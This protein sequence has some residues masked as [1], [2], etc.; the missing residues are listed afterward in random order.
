MRL[1]YMCL[2]TQVMWSQII[3]RRDKTCVECFQ[4]ILGKEISSMFQKASR[5]RNLRGY[6]LY[7][8]LP[9]EIAI[10]IDT[11]IACIHNSIKLRAFNFDTRIISL[12][13]QGLVLLL[14]GN[15]HWTSFKDIQRKLV[16]L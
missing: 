6:C 13:L 5:S 3:E 1:E 16:S 14:G 11:K 15:K 9:I 7:V 8:L 4:C 2:V 12:V 10:S